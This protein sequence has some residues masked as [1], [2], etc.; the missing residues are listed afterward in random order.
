MAPLPPQHVVGHGRRVVVVLDALADADHRDGK[1]ELLGGDAIDRCG[2]LAEVSG[3]IDVR[4]G[5]LVE[6]PRLDEEA[7]PLAA[8]LLCDPHGVVHG[9]QR[10]LH[11]ERVGQID[12]PGT[13]EKL[14]QRRTHPLAE[15]IS[16]TTD[17][18]GKLRCRLQDVRQRAAERA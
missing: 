5:M 15:L 9:E 12:H 2:A 1:D 6:G 13:A 17:S 4:A 18:P 8:E 10:E 16:R 14:A 3:R 11:R 7:V